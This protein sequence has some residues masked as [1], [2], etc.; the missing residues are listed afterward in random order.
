MESG[1]DHVG[2]DAGVGGI[3]ALGHVREVAVRVVDMEELGEDAVLEV[4]E[5][6][7]GQHSAG[8][9]GVASLGLEG[10]PVGCDGGD[11]D[12]VA[13]L[14]VLDLG[15]DLDDL[16]GGLVAEDHVVAITDCTLPQ[17]VDIRGADGDCERLDDGIER[18]TLGHVL[19]D[20]TRLANL[21]HCI[22]LHG[23][24]PSLCCLP[25]LPSLHDHPT[26]VQRR[27]WSGKVYHRIQF[28]DRARLGG[29]LAPDAN[30][31]GNEHACCHKQPQGGKG[32]GAIACLGKPAGSRGA[33]VRVGDR[34]RGVHACA[35]R[36]D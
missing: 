6:P 23:T 14:E 13:G 7:A 34:D 1:G 36:L 17:R 30:A 22:A 2:Q 24:T 26:L 27:G 8:V 32:I 33:H 12:A 31:D 18:T 4:G 10:V 21:E 11:E 35:I 29:V 3:H 20:P 19:L 25:A 28:R 16:A 15:A 5:L 9:H